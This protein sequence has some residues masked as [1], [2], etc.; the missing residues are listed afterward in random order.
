[1]SNNDEQLVLNDVE[2]TNNGTH[3]S[4]VGKDLKSIPR[5]LH[6][7]FGGSILSLDLSF[8]QLT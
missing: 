2:L 4:I 8:N 1:M 5:E 7:R 3:L 6:G